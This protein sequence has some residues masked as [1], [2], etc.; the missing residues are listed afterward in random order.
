MS[1][2]AAIAPHPSG[3]RHVL[4]NPLRW[5]VQAIERHTQA[6]IQHAVPNYQL[7]RLRREKLQL[8]R[9]VHPNA[10]VKPFRKRESAGSKTEYRNGTC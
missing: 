8:Q 2:F 5:L 10:S 1:A 7:R 3:A 4:R 6:R 9:A